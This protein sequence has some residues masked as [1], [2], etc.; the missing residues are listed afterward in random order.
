MQDDYRI[1]I[2]QRHRPLDETP[3]AIV[4]FLKTLVDEIVPGV[5]I[6][7]EK[8]SVFY[9]ILLNAKQTYPKDTYYNRK[10]YF[11]L[12][13]KFFE[14][15][16]YKSYFPHT[17]STKNERVEL[18]KNVVMR[19]KATKPGGDIGTLQGGAK[20]ETRRIKRKSGGNKRT[21]RSR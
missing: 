19:I 9:D 17:T 12:L 21:R 11:V 14:D 10:L 7:K 18:R 8:T 3:Q 15:N 4:K 20:K 5:K 1:Y 6:D 13:N 2:A 16:T